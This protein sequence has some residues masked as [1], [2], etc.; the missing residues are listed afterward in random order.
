MFI[1]NL[2]IQ[3]YLPSDSE[4]LKHSLGNHSCIHASQNQTFFKWKTHISSFM[5]A[6]S[7]DHEIN[8]ATL[9]AKFGFKMKNCLSSNIL[10]LF[11]SLFHNLDPFLYGRLN[12]PVTKFENMVAKQN[13]HS[14]ASHSLHFL[15]SDTL[16][17]L[18]WRAWTKFRPE[19]KACAWEKRD[20]YNQ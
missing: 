13:H 10:I 17:G 6:A 20:I 4:G 11:Q 18:R 19:K 12:V 7:W 5:S 15:H 16:Y 8:P 2:Y 3:T 14:F 1:Y 9:L